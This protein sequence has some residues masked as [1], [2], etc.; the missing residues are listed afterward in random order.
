MYHWFLFPIISIPI[1]V[2]CVIYCTYIAVIILFL[3]TILY[4]T[5]DDCVSSSVQNIRSLI[6]ARHWPF[7]VYLISRIMR[8]WGRNIWQL[9]EIFEE[10]LMVLTLV[11]YSAKFL[12]ITIFRG[13]L[14]WR[15]T[16]RLRINQN[17][18]LIWEKLLSILIVFAS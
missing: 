14:G 1:N 13:S 7:L 4:R 17:T 5:A 3:L 15:L 9:N 8:I 16:H 2:W 10:P 11:T 18:I 12:G 6:H